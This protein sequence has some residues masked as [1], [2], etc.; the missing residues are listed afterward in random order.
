[1][2]RA[3]VTDTD[4]VMVI[5]CAW[6]MGAVIRAA[7]RG[8]T[9]IAVDVDDD[10]LAIV[11]TVGATHTVNAKRTDLHERLMTLTHGLMPTWWSRRWAR[12]YQK[13]A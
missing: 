12:P 2:D 4:V 10:K 11:K 7:V 13:K 6:G 3:Q 9:V 1:V 8:A 5:G